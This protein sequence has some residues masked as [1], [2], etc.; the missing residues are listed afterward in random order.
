MVRRLIFKTVIILSILISCARNEK[1][2]VKETIPSTKPEDVIHEVKNRDYSF[3]VKTLKDTLDI[4]SLKLIVFK[5]YLEPHSKSLNEIV[6]IESIWDGKIQE[7]GNCVI[8]NINLS[9][10]LPSTFC[11]SLKLIYSNDKSE[12]FLIEL[13]D[14]IPVQLEVQNIFLVS[15]VVKSRGFGIFVVYNLKEGLLKKIFETSESIYNQ[16]LTCNSF[17]NGYLNFS[18]E[19]VNGDN[20]FDLLFSGLEYSYCHG[21]EQGFNYTNRSPVDS[22]FRKV[23]YLGGENKNKEPIW[24]EMK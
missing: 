6:K 22:T 24:Q 9:E 10:S 13:D 7:L 23:V 8:Y 21:L 1:Q 17:K 14:F 12:A 3:G 20:F 19:D 4:E 11:K 15:G 18:N 2:P 5:E 16:S